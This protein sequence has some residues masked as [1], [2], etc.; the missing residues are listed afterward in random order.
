MPRGRTWVVVLACGIVLVGGCALWALL[1]QRVGTDVCT[2]PRV[3]LRAGAVRCH[4]HRHRLSRARVQLS[5]AQPRHTSF[6]LDME[7]YG[8]GVAPR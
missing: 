1:V 6:V 8:A 2:L 5:G 7:V 4:L 3:P